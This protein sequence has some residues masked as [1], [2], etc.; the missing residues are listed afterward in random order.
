MAL[1]REK[2]Q[3]NRNKNICK[4]YLCMIGNKYITSI[5]KKKKKLNTDEGRHGVNTNNELH[6]FWRVF[7]N[8][9]EQ[10]LQ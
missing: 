5:R 3:R 6:F 4:F 10:R 8:W 9:I 2:S 1:M 7:L